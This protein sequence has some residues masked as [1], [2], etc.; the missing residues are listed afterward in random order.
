MFGSDWDPYQ[1]LVDLRVELE[2][3]KANLQVIIHSH[4]KLN[5]ENTRLRKWS[6][7]QQQ[8]LLELRHHVDVLKEQR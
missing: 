4:N 7:E 5:H 8:E 2:L 1:E 6:Q 3:I